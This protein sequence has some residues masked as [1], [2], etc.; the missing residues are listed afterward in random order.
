MWKES[1][2]VSRYLVIRDLNYMADRY[3]SRDL[4]RVLRVLRPPQL[5]A[6]LTAYLFFNVVVHGVSEATLGT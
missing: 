4:A 3:S 6:L 2:R 1:T 5:A